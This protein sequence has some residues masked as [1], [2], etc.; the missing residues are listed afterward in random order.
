MTGRRFGS[1]P[2]EPSERYGRSQR[3]SGS[4]RR[5]GIAVRVTFGYVAGYL[6]PWLRLAAA[7]RPGGAC[8]WAVDAYRAAPAR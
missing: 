6:L 2:V 7:V 3:P 1:Q 5:F 8:L 4:I